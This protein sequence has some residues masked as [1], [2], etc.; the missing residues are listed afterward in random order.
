[1][2]GPAPPARLKAAPVFVVT[3]RRNVQ[4][5]LDRIVR[6]PFDGPPLGEL[7]DREGGRGDDREQNAM[8]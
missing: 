6:Q 1:M 8:R 2:I 3:W 7:V 5:S 4:K